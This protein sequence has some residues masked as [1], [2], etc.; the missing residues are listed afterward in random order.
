MEWNKFGRGPIKSKI[1]KSP[2]K[3]RL[4]SL[5]DQEFVHWGVGRILWSV[6][7]SGSPAALGKVP[8]HL[9]ATELAGKLPD[10]C[11]QTCFC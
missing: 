5:D 1:Q 6:G 8:G 10:G 9:R 7:N 11:Y 4:Q 3:E 2:E